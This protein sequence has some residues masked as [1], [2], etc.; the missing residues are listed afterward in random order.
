MSDGVGLY[1]ED[2]EEEEEENF[3]EDKDEEEGDIDRSQRNARMSD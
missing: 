2:E 3:E 1:Q